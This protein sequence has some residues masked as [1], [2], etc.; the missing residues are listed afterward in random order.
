MSIKNVNVGDSVF[1][2][3]FIARELQRFEVFEVKEDYVTLKRGDKI[4]LSCSGEYWHEFPQDALNWALDMI[5]K[6]TADTSKALSIYL[7]EMSSL[8]KTAE[9]I[10]KDL[11][12][13]SYV[14]LVRNSLHKEVD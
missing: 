2:Y 8:L 13:K 1:T 7:N 5:N 3:D 6:Q 10:K 14:D 4:I 11:D 9:C 12:T